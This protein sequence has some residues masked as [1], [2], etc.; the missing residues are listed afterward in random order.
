MCKLNKSIYGLRQASLQW[1]SKLSNTLLEIDFVQSK[2]D[3]TVF[4]L[5]RGPS[6][7]G[8]LFYV[9]DIVIA[10]FDLP[11]VSDLKVF[12]NNNFNLKDVVNMKYF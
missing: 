6:F 4:S 9:D 2:S 7:I 12:L 1:Y 11:V 10:S 3:Y 8:F 5:T